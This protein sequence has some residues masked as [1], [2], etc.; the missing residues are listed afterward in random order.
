MENKLRWWV[1][2]LPSDTT[3]NLCDGSVLSL[4]FKRRICVLDNEYQFKILRFSKLYKMA[5]RYY[6]KIVNNLLF[7][8][9]KAN[10]AQSMHL[11]G[12]Y[13]FPSSVQIIA[14]K[15]ILEDSLNYFLTQWIATELSRVVL[16]SNLQIVLNTTQRSKL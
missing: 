5:L 16:L 11:G 7:L 1:G 8:F 13:Q 2:H 12:W 9:W 6:F 3:A 14:I 4:F 10:T 15:A